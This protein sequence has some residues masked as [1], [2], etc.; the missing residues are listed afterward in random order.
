MV[1]QKQLSG[2]E[3]VRSSAILEKR[4]EFFADLSGWP[5]S[6]CDELANLRSRQR[7]QRLLRLFKPPAETMIYV[8]FV[9]QLL[10]RTAS[11]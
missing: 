10:R 3:Q 2:A 4:T 11:F 1:Y 6:I 5:A 7:A 8:A 9:H